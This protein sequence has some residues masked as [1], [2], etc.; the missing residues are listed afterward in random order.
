MST[1]TRSRNAG[2]TLDRSVMVRSAWS[3]RRSSGDII[4]SS[5]IGTNRGSSMCLG[6]RVVH[7]CGRAKN[8]LKTA[9]SAKENSGSSTSA[10]GGGR[11][12]TVA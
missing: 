11:R 2:S 8:V 7:D 4:S 9:R 1:L 6:C 12:F 3:A 10:K 5:V